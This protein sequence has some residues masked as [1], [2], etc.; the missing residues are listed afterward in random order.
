VIRNTVLAGGA[1]KA[2]FH[3]GGLRPA[4]QHSI[5]LGM[6]TGVSAGAI[7][8]TFV[9][10][11][12]KAREI[13]EIL[14]QAL[15]KRFSPKLAQQCLEEARR[16]FS[17]WASPSLV[18]A[19]TRAVSACFLPFILGRGGLEE[20]ADA[21]SALNAEV[22]DT[23]EQILT[24]QSRIVA[25]KGSILDIERPLK[26]MC[27]EYGLTGK[28]NLRIIGCGIVPFDK[29]TGDASSGEGLVAQGASSRRIPLVFEGED[30]DLGHALGITCA[31]PSVFMA[32]PHRM[33]DG[34]VVMG[35]DGALWN[36]N[37]TEFCDT[38]AIVFM[39]RRVTTAFPEEFQTPFD[40]GFHGLERFA[41]LAGDTKKLDGRNHLVIMFGLPH[42]AGLNFGMSEQTYRSMADHAEAVA[43]PLLLEGLRSGRLR[44]K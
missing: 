17:W 20:M 5:D 25:G 28:Q 30:I 24:F 19:W 39:F 18:Q 40:V 34:T 21:L 7:V 3:T 15:K 16:A 11:G 10:N 13:E 26:E 29:N 41:P 4:E 14:L 27:A 12:Y 2:L 23:L 22:N 35:I 8:A 44:Q 6:L 36:H 9:A 42:T 31:L 38:P 43:T 33:P 37:P 32:V 1:A